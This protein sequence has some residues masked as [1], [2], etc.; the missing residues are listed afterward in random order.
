MSYLSTSHS[1]DTKS[2]KILAYP[3]HNSTLF[4]KLP[5]YIGLRMLNKL[6]YELKHEMPL[7][8]FKK[9]LKNLLLE[10]CFYSVE[11]YLNS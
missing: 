4:E 5:F 3:Q 2:N 7:N 1:Y 11:E 6:P 10:K 9:K 8:T